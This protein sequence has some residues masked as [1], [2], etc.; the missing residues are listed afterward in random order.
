M[1][2]RQFLDQHAARLR[3]R[4]RSGSAAIHDEIERAIGP[5]VREHPRMSAVAAAS[6]G[7]ALGLVLGRPSRSGV[8][9]PRRGPVTGTV[10]FIKDTGVFA[11]RSYLVSSL[12]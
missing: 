3:E 4:I 10:R 11:L 7:L 6:A 8:A 1:T 12:R 2:E 9:G 5:G